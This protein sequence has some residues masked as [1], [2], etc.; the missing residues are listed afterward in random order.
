MLFD[1]YKNEATFRAEFV[2]PLLTKMGFMSIAELDGSLE[3]GKDF[4]FSELTPFGF[5]RHY[6]VV[7]K[8]EKSIRQT[9]TKVCQTI[10][11]QIQQAFSVKF[12]LSES[13]QECHVSSALVLNSGKITPNAITWFRSELDRERY[14]ENVHIFDN[15]RLSQLNNQVAFNHQE[16]LLPRLAGLE[17]N[18]KLN[19]LVWASISKSLPVF[20]EAR[21]SFIYALENYLVA[22]FLTDHI[23]I[24]EVG[25][26]L[27]ESKIIDAINQRYL[28]GVR[29]KGEIKEQEIEK[30][31]RILEKATQRAL[32]IELNIKKC[33][34]EFKP[35]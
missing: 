11:S 10:L 28:M 6:G 12:R 33:L 24:S 30:L 34:M 23:N 14:G 21:G 9:S 19:R 15:E 17:A 25:T 20:S 22:P 31:K 32:L 8:H 7:V 35:I 18:L 4:V 13:S 27:Q 5:F 29:V 26:L 16:L 2:R 3:F 1:N